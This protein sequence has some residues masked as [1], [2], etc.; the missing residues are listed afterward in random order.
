[1]FQS[2]TSS[3]AERPETDRK[4]PPRT[5]SEPRIPARIRVAIG[6]GAVTLLAVVTFVIFQLIPRHEPRS[7]AAD[8]APKTAMPP[9]SRINGPRATRPVHFARNVFVL[10]HLRPN[11][12]SSPR[13]QHRTEAGRSAPHSRK[14]AVPTL[15]RPPAGNRQ[16]KDRGKRKNWPPGTPRAKNRN[17]NLKHK[18]ARA[19]GKHVRRQPIRA[20]SPGTETRFGQG[21]TRKDPASPRSYSDQIVIPTG[22]YNL[23]PS[24]AD[25]HGRPAK[26][27]GD[28]AENRIEEDSSALELT[29]SPS[30][31]LELEPKL[32]DRLDEPGSDKWKDKWRS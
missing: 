2:L 7:T 23:A 12:K 10:P 26:M 9:R 14:P 8:P 28:R 3:A 15:W 13:D 19:R 20:R 16:R 17:A 22:M 5:E 27:V 24:H 21:D 25:R 6:A 32:A 11:P 31:D 30:K 4:S 1:M 29:L 18:K